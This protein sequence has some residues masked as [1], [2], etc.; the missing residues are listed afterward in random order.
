MQQAAYDP[1]SSQGILLALGTGIGAAHAILW[2]F[3]GKTSALAKYEEKINQM[4]YEYLKK[5]VAYYNKERRWP[6]SIFWK[7]STRLTNVH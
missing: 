5:R 2:H 1:L 7:Q 6:E 3:D 4:F